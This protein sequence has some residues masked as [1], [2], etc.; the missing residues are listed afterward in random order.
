MPNKHS[1]QRV[2]DGIHLPISY[3]FASATARSATG[4]Y[5]A[6]DVGKFAR[7]TDTNALYWL[8]AVTTPGSSAT[9]I[10][11]AIGSATNTDSLPEGTTNL[12]FTAERVDDRVFGLLAA[13][14]NVSLTY[15]DAAN[16]LIIA[17]AA[18]ASTFSDAA[19]R[20]QDDTDPTKQIA[21]QAVGLTTGTTRIITTP[22]KN[23]ILVGEDLANIFTKRQAVAPVTLA[24]ATSIAPD[25]SLSNSFLVTLTGNLTLANPTGLV[26]GASFTITLTQDATG[27]RTIAFGTAYK[28]PGGTAPA[29]ST[30]ANAKD[31]LFCHSDN[32]TTL[33][34]V[35][36][37]DFR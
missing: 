1:L 7:Q 5:L 35:L 13:G 27:G 24:Y 14:S 3:E 11:T 6:S 28:F 9:P 21:F 16:T 20:I 19:F 12:Y 4:S 15:D 34:C 18:G 29:L 17:A 32:G 10:W 2:A 33:D 36:N 23:L 22:D 26:A 30:A 31:K 37:K 8:S 25:L